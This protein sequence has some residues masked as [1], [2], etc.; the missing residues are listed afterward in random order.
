MNTAPALRT[1]ALTVSTDINPRPDVSGEVDMLPVELVSTVAVL[2]DACVD[3]GEP[4][5]VPPRVVT[6]VAPVPEVCDDVDGPEAAA[7][8]VVPASIPLSEVGKGTA[9]ATTTGLA[10]DSASVGALTTDRFS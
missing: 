2:S 9:G 1:G 10:S 6:A 8:E 3:A 7:A 5:G 4:E